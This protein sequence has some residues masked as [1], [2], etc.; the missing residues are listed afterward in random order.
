MSSTA[1]A[2]MSRKRDGRPSWLPRRSERAAYLFV[3]FAA[4]NALGLAWDV[5]AGSTGAGEA[6]AGVGGRRGLLHKDFTPEERVRCLQATCPRTWRRSR[7]FL[8]HG[9]A[10]TPEAARNGR[11]GLIVPPLSQFMGIFY[12]LG[13]LYCLIGLAEVC[14]NFFVASLEE[15]GTRFGLSEDVS[16]APCTPWQ[17]EPARVPSPRRRRITPW[18]SGKG[19]GEAL[20]ASASAQRTSSR[21]SE[22]TGRLSCRFAGATLMAAGSSLPE[23]FSSFVALA[24]PDTDN[25]LGM[26]TIVGSSVYNTLVIVGCSAIAGT[27]G[28]PATICFAMGRFRAVLWLKR[29]R[30]CHRR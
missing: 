10:A 22:T 8:Q 24:N 3:A 12:A 27:E 25:T 13:V 6:V 29:A 20:V 28:L 15:L 4:V 14:E 7:I 18:P 23:V 21:C 1:S 2:R 16:G 5:V 9:F 26:D 30:C 19:A 17:S 11:C